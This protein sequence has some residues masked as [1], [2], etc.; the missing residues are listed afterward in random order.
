MGIAAVSIS[1]TE[2]IIMGGMGP[3]KNTTNKLDY[4][5]SRY[6]CER[7]SKENNVEQRLKAAS[8]GQ[9]DPNADFKVCK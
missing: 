2:G 5:Y 6:L 4:N 1:D 3:G 9:S 7:Y 8:L